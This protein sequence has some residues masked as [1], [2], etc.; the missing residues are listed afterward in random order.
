MKIFRAKPPPTS[1][2]ITRSLCS[3]ADEAAD[4]EPRDADLATF[5]NVIVGAGVII[6]KRGPRL[7]CAR[8]QPI[9]DDVELC[10]YWWRQ[11]AAST[12]F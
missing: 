1:G 7:Y 3:G 11:Q 10:K 12:A 6:G 2:A 9:V 4:D 5:H 8:H